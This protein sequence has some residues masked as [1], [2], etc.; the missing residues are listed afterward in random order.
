MARFVAK[1]C[2][3]VYA[4]LREFDSKHGS[5][6]TPYYIG[7]GKEG[8][9]FTS[10]GRH[11]PMPKDKNRIVFIAEKLS[12]VDA[13]Q[14]EILMIALWGRLDLGRGCLL[15]FTDGGE[16]CSGRKM[17]PSAIALLAMARRG[18]GVSEATRLK[19]SASRKGKINSRESIERARRANTGMKRSGIALDNL[20]AGRK[21]RDEAVIRVRIAATLKGHHV[22]MEVREKLRSAQTGRKLSED[23]RL[24]MSEAQFRRHN[25]LPPLPGQI[26]VW[27]KRSSKPTER[28]VLTEAHCQDQDLD[29]HDST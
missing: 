22:S 8:R 24:R 26:G 13:R 25:R 2:Y 21:N 12:D 17:S 28:I 7:K 4:Y 9:A 3:Y 27:T 23:V 16:G 6:G 14:T 29:G 19:I 10:Y 15:N 20:R 18:K 5:A 1:R 11:V